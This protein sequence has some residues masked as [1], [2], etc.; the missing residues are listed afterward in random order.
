[1]GAHALVTD[2]DSPAVEACVT[3]AGAVF[4]STLRVDVSSTTRGTELLLALKIEQRIT[5]DPAMLD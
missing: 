3:Y 1:M 2:T 4:S 5:V